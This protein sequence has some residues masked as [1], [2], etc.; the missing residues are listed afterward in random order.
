MF[1]L[2]QITSLVDNENLQAAVVLDTNVFMIDTPFVDECVLNNNSVVFVISPSVVAELEKLSDDKNV[3]TASRARMGRN[4]INDLYDRG[5]IN[6]GILVDKVGWFISV[7]LPDEETIRPEL[8]KKRRFIKSHGDWDIILV[9]LVQ[10]CHNIL[11]MIPSILAT[12]DRGLSNIAQQQGLLSYN[13]SYKDKWSRF[14]EVLNKRKKVNDTK[15]TIHKGIHDFL[16]KY[17]NDEVM[18]DAL[19]QWATNTT[20]VTAAVTRMHP[21]NHG[22]LK[23]NLKL[24]YDFTNEQSEQIYSKLRSEIEKAGFE[25]STGYLEA[26]ENI[27]EHFAHESILR[28]ISLERLNAAPLNIQYIAWLFAKLKTKHPFFPNIGNWAQFSALMDATFSIQITD[29]TQQVIDP[30]IKLGFLNDLEW[31]GSKIREDSRKLENRLEFPQYLEPVTSSIDRYISLPDLPDFR[32]LIDAMFNRKRSSALTAFEEL[33]Q[34]TCLPQADWT[35][36]DPNI[37]KQTIPQPYLIG[38]YQSVYAINMRVYDEVG[39]N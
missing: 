21:P 25:F 16:A 36:T 13:Y 22:L 17:Q 1:D 14:Q 35:T 39:W 20:G 15:Q 29:I 2:R 10:E 4:F 34:G 19:Y 9:L 23:S 11:S 32:K 3:G 37:T 8:D 38:K 18:L 7:K 5:D 12:T 33:I 30:L 27:K 6:T 26:K 31:V 28:E 24:R